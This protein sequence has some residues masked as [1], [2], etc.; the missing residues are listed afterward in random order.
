MAEAAPQKAVFPREPNAETRMVVGE[1]RTTYIY[2]H[3]YMSGDIAFHVFF[4]CPS[5]ACFRICRG[6]MASVF[7]SFCLCFFLPPHPP[8]RFAAGGSYARERTP[9]RSWGNG[10]HGDVD[11]TVKDTEYAAPKRQGDLVATSYPYSSL[12]AYTGG[13]NPN[14]LHE[15][16]RR[17]MVNEHGSSPD[18]VCRQQQ[19]QQQQHVPEEQQ[20]SSYSEQYRSRQQHGSYPASLLSPVDA[21]HRRD[22][23][24]RNAAAAPSEDWEKTRPRLTQ[25]MSTEQPQ[26]DENNPPSHRPYPQPFSKASEQP[27]ARAGGI[28]IDLRDDDEGTLGP[29][30]ALKS[31][32][33]DTV[34]GQSKQ[35]KY[36]PPQEQPAENNVPVLS[37][38]HLL[39]AKVPKKGHYLPAAKVTDE[40]TGLVFQNLLR[41]DEGGGA[42]AGVKEWIPDFSAQEESHHAT[43]DAGSSPSPYP[44]PSP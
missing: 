43:N 7:L 22:D 9:T 4:C 18:D 19:R 30:P 35:G 6:S 36:M 20:Y 32:G 44:S 41:N 42:A 29:K 38:G 13:G 25:G 27:Q 5:C 37:K 21:N 28:L 33:D 39:A 16:R 17:T 15:D 23:L 8:G 12:H 10:H 2:I 11:R 31:R 3:I 34:A 24:V 40:D 26:R 1:G 14:L